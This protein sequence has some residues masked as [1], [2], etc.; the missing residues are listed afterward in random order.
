MN[1]CISST[2]ETEGGKR[3]TNLR[4]ARAAQ[5]DIV[6]K[7]ENRINKAGQ[8]DICSALYLFGKGER[9]QEGSG[10][11]GQPELDDKES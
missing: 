7:K 1:S 11:Q 5:W 9:R 10:I 3:I 4:S 2:K 6:K 8:S